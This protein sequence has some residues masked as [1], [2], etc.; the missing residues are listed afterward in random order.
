MYTDA[1]I[2]D[3]SND[4]LGRAPFAQYLADFLTGLPSSHSTVVAL[5]GKWGSGKTSLLNMTIKQIE[6]QQQQPII[7]KFDPWN[8]VNEEQLISGFFASLRSALAES[9][10]GEKAKQALSSIT[11]ALSDYA[12][13]LL[14]LDSILHT[15]G[16]TVSLKE[17]SAAIGKVLQDKLALDNNAAKLKKSVSKELEKAN[18]TV[19]VVIDDI[20]RLPNRMICLLF[21]LV[22]QIADFPRVHYV[23]AYDPDIVTRA[24]HEIQ[25]CEGSEYLEKVVQLPLGIPQISRQALYR[26]LHDEMQDSIVHNYDDDDP[27]LERAE[28]VL[29]SCVGP[30][31]ASMRDLRRYQNLFLFEYSFVSKH[32]STI[33]LAALVAIKVFTPGILPWIDANLFQL[34]GASG[35]ES[36]TKPDDEFSR[37]SNQ[38]KQQLGSKSALTMSVISCL[39]FLFPKFANSHGQRTNPITDQQLRM[40]ARCASVEVWTH[41]RNGLLDT[42]KYPREEIKRLLLSGTREELLGAL[43]GSIDAVDFG[44]ELRGLISMLGEQRAETVAA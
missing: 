14:P 41:Y 35:G 4:L 40:N 20:D 27:E 9:L 15:F 7:V 31:L 30:F 5:Q 19:I 38:I 42:W 2:L 37:V 33:D 23:L 24:I 44:E 22:A 21:Q 6:Q 26:I 18:L 32:M 13:V 17:T 29:F 43:D 16:L 36:S 39:D 12:F 34:C 11:K 8:C 25:N 28:K 10:T 3:V 1:P